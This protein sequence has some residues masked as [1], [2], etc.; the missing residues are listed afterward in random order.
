MVSIKH[1]FITFLTLL[2]PFLLFSEGMKQ[3][4]PDSLYYTTLYIT[5]NPNCFG[6]EFCDIDHK[7]YVHI[8][9]PGEKIYMGFASVYGGVTVKLQLNGTLMYG[10]VNTSSS[11][12]GF[13]KYFSQA[14]V[15]PDVLGSGGY[16]PISYAP[17]YPGDYEI[18]LSMGSLLQLDVTVIDTTITPYAA[19][20]GRLWAK[21]WNFKSNSINIPTNAFLGTMYIYSE[22]SVVTSIF[23]NNMQGDLFTVSCN[24]NGCYPPPMPWDS[25]CKSALYNHSYPQYKIFVN[26]PDT[27]CYPTGII[28]TINENNLTVTQGCDGSFT[29]HFFVGKSGLVKALFNIN[30]LPGIQPEDVVIMDSVQAGWNDLN[31]N[32][33]NGLGQSL[34]TGTQIPLILT[35]INGL[36]NFPV[37]D[38]ER[39]LH[40]FVVTQVRP[41]GPPIATYWNDTLLASQGGRTQLNGCYSYDTVGC[42][43]WNGN[44]GGIGIGSENTV[45]TWWYAASETNPIMLIV[46]RAP[47]APDDITGPTTFCQSAV[48]TY[49]I[50]PFPI[51]GANDNL[52]EWV[53]T[54]DVTNTVLV[55][56]VNQGPS[57]TLSFS[58]FPAGPM[59]LKVRGQNFL[60]GYGPFGPGTSGAGIQLQANISPHL[61]NTVTSFS[62]CS[63]NAININLQSTIS[64][65][66]YSYTATATSGFI[67]GYVGGTANP[68]QQILINTGGEVDSVIYRVV[69]FALSCPGDTVNFYIA[70]TPIPQVTNIVT[71]YQVCSGN[72]TNII[73]SSNVTST[74]FSWIATGSDPSV[75]GYSSSGG[76]IIAQTL[77][78]SGTVDQT[79]TYLVTPS[80]NSC[81]GTQKVFTVTVTPG[82]PVSININPSVNP[83]CAN[84]L[85]TF[86]AT[87]TNQG[88]SPV[89][90]WNVNGIDQGTNSNIFSYI[91][92]NNDLVTCIVTS[93]NTIC[94]SNNPA[95]SNS[96]T[97]V[98]Y[99][100]LPVS[101]SI[102]TSAN[103]F[104]Q[105]SSVTFTATPTNGGSTPSYQWRVNGVNAGTN[106]PN[107]IYNPVNNDQVSCILTSS[108]LCTSGNPAS[109]ITITMVEN[110]SLPAGVSIA[111]SSNPFCPG[112]SVAFT[113]SPTNG[114][115][116]PAYQWKVNGINVGT[117][118]PTYTYNPSDNDS[119]RCIMTSNLACITGNPASSAKIIMRG[120]L[121]PIV[122]FTSCF[123]TITTINAKPIK[124]KGG[125]PLGGI[126]S[127]PGVNSVTGIFTP[128][129]AGIGTHTITYTYTNTALCSAAKSIS[130]LN[131][132]SSILI[133]GNPLTDI[134]DNKVYP[135]V[136]IGSQCWLA[137]NLNYGT[138]L[139]SSQDQRD[140]C[141]AE[142]YCYNDNPINCINY[143]GLYQW[144]EL[145]QF[146]ETPADQGFCPPSWHIPSENDWNTLFATFINNGFAGSPLKYSGYSGFNALLSGARHI[147]KGWDFQGFATFFWSSTARSD[148]K[149]WAHGMNDVDPSVSIYPASRV[150]GFSVRCLKD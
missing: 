101:I 149:A 120:T 27:I 46:Q 44:Y 73:L 95:T 93:S 77:V 139:S 114:G 69:P 141:I 48:N 83:V 52:Y 1:F 142:K 96:I 70:I 9:H 51:L 40:G 104:C 106:S 105:G 84:N 53:L 71:S 39:H 124:L 38:L 146:D 136:Q 36:T 92:L 122:T 90:Q 147:N 117:N 121:A 13:I 26:N 109:S 18:D 66:T 10:P 14:Y 76:P 58:T 132:P 103:P 128:S 80:L 68:I 119:V 86:T 4:T 37:Y 97:M 35:F 8:D 63:G 87:C 100:N 126:Y 131:L 23:F 118:S 16:H 79:V 65:T 50:V 12:N 57:I 88:S 150:N 29:I 6:T 110:N 102:S 145:M 81:N 137:S 85:V 67:S 111:A 135:T 17:V 94:V 62:I 98:V 21:T 61:T 112:S 123:D 56:L 31:W 72:T 134:R 89:F 3:L 22:D 116:A 32:G 45:N 130:I 55:D 148:N 2:M 78:N 34:S 54:D 140:N 74:T 113:A 25:S 19:T 24:A 30:P 107:F 20:N 7:L 133:C 47:L 11:S 99:P 108:E 42:H 41:S 91:P 82:Q 43:R 143:G 64:S 144:D 60:C 33:L 138:I 15:G 5:S 115:S 125:I 75:S 49:T 28:G 59:H 127:G 129:L